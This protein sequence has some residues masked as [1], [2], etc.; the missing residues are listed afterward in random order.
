MTGAPSGAATDAIAAIFMLIW[1]ALPPILGLVILHLLLRQG[2]ER[3]RAD[4]E[5][6]ELRRLLRA[7]RLKSAGLR[8]EIAR[9]HAQAQQMLD[10]A[11]AARQTI[12][13]LEQRLDGFDACAELQQARQ[14]I[15][16]LQQRNLALTMHALA[17]SGRLIKRYD[18]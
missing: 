3:G 7:E 9:I 6:A 11:R 4:G 8:E 17:Q 12:L 2:E 10:A 15:V 5:A 13:G 1:K 18:N 16:T 14:H